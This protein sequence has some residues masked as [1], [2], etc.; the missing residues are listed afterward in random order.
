MSDFFPVLEGR[1][2]FEKYVLER[3]DR[4]CLFSTLSQKV[5]IIL[6]FCLVYRSKDGL[7]SL[8]FS[9]IPSLF[10]KRP[11]LSPLQIQI[12]LL[13]M[14]P[15]LRLSDHDHSCSNIF[16][17]MQN[18]FALSLSTHSCSLFLIFL[19]SIPLMVLLLLLLRQLIGTI[20]SLPQVFSRIGP[21]QIPAMNVER[22]EKYL[23]KWP[24]ENAVA[25]PPELTSLPTPTIGRCSI[26]RADMM[27]DSPGRKKTFKTKTWPATGDFLRR[28]TT[29]EVNRCR[30]HVVFFERRAE[31][32]R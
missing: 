10:L 29:E 24:P 21:E 7:E 3:A 4:G 30:R 28:D 16:P 18:I 5:G 32:G 22:L 14:A 6:L 25:L 31:R 17:W 20:I 27:S 8:A 26:R 15:I 19:L 13:G 1:I 12:S 9:H 11:Y 23:K 2:I